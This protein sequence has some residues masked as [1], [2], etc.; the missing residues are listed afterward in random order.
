MIKD[1][2]PL[3]SSRGLEYL[4]ARRVAVTGAS[5]L[6]GSYVV[7]FLR[8]LGAEVRAI[9]H[10][11]PP[12]E[13]TKMANEI[14][15]VDLSCGV[16]VHGAAANSKIFEGCSVVA[17]CAGI[18]GGVNLPS[19][20]PVSYVGPA[21]V[22]AMNTLHAAHL[23]RVERIGWLSSTTVYPPLDRP[24]TEDDSRLPDALYP[25]Y[26]GIGESKR[27]LEK[28]FAYYHE[29]AGIGAAVVRPS[30]AYGRFDNFDERT[31]HV[32]PGM[33]TRALKLEPG[34]LF[35]VWGDGEDVRDFIHAQDVARCLLLAISKDVTARPYNVASGL[36]VTTKMLARAVLN[37]VGSVTDIRTQPNMPTALRRRLVDVSR[38]KEELGFVA[39]IPLARGVQDVVDYRRPT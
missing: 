12:N 9:I 11:R 20:D 26:R 30:G 5:G 39:Q 24:A 36:G 15:Q 31:S 8:E 10:D 29:T 22:I 4:I 28:L 13:F 7:K 1:P 35:D 14:V 17:S 6:I 32:L 21:S 27:F 3:T 19:H 34:Q 18:T 38:A 25:L 33:V 16:G 23:A 2:F 37:A